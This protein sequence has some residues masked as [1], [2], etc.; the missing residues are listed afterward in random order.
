MASLCEDSLL[1]AHIRADV[2]HDAGNGLVYTPPISRL[3]NPRLAEL[4][5]QSG[6]V[7]QSEQTDFLDPRDHGFEET[8][9]LNFTRNANKIPIYFLI[10]NDTAL[11]SNNSVFTP[12]QDPNSDLGIVYDA[13]K[14][15]FQCLP[16]SWNLGNVGT[17]IDPASKKVG[18]LNRYIYRPFTE[19]TIIPA[20][21]FGFNSNVVGGIRFSDFT[22]TSLKCA[23]QYTAVGDTMR[24]YDAATTQPCRPDFSDLVVIGVGDRR[25]FFQGNSANTTLNPADPLYGLHYVGKALGDAFQVYALDSRFAGIFTNYS[26]YDSTGDLRPDSLRNLMISTGDKLN[27]ARAIRIG[28][29]SAYISKLAGELVHTG[30]FVPGNRG[31]VSYAQKLAEYTVRFNNIVDTVVRRYTTIIR[32]IHDAH[33]PGFQSRY[34]VFGEGQ[35][36]LADGNENA[37]KYFEETMLNVTHI[38]LAVEHFFTYEISLALTK[39]Q[40]RAETDDEHIMRLA[41][42]YTALN[43]IVDTLCP[44]GSLTNRRTVNR[45]MF[46]KI[47][48][49]VVKDLNFPARFATDRSRIFQGPTRYSIVM[50]DP[51]GN[52]GVFM[53][54]YTINLYQ[55]LLRI[56]RGEAILPPNWG[57]VGVVGGRKTRLRRSKKRK[58]RRQRGGGFK[59]DLLSSISKIPPTEEKITMPEFTWDVHIDVIEVADLEAIT[60][61]NNF[62]CHLNA[63]NARVLGLYEN[64]DIII[65][66]DSELA[67]YY[68]SQIKPVEYTAVPD[69]KIDFNDIVF[70]NDNLT[71]F[72]Q[73][74]NFI[75]DYRKISKSQATVY[76]ANVIR[77]VIKFVGTLDDNVVIYEMAEEIPAIGRAF[78]RDEE[79]GR[80]ETGFM[81]P[82]P[83]AAPSA[84]AYNP[85]L[86]FVQSP[87]QSQ[88]SVATTFSSFQSPDG[89]SGPRDSSSGNVSDGSKGGRRTRRK[90]PKVTLF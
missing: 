53:G 19:Q 76:A 67:T 42:R 57:S 24:W 49:C 21:V 52:R 46:P 86:S 36:L 4:V 38:G 61:Y 84:A 12:F 80:A 35:P 45:R 87:P 48:I 47:K 43:S 23:I 65:D 31:V 32:E 22:G 5:G 63:Q 89:S 66:T 83:R 60:L 11:S 2:E 29:S 82:I 6:L 33:V 34:S 55:D 37:R 74:V 77:V 28:V 10:R 39:L 27:H 1:M 14:A 72:A 73:F 51:R 85:L 79:M 75:L 69:I 17:I 25:G 18:P 40:T 71:V 50:N 16:G 9:V 7:L 64:G 90:T 41:R 70:P 8:Y 88:A 30:S 62:V 58:T 15:L 26:P 56:S 78:P 44:S 81:T 68:E 3:F 59:E 13:G 54:T 20:C